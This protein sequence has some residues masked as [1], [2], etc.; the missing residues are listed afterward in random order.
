[1][2]FRHR[3][4]DPRSWVAELWLQ[5]KTLDQIAGFVK[6]LMGA[7]IKIPVASVLVERHR[8]EYGFLWNLVRSDRDKFLVS[9]SVTKMKT[10]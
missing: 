9:F 8:F 4:V 5:H 3:P 1:M 2:F 6:D 7:G 10:T